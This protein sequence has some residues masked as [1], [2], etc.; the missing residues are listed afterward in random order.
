[1]LIW[2]PRLQLQ[3]KQISSLTDPTFSHLRPSERADFPYALL[4]THFQR[5][6]VSTSRSLL[7]DCLDTRRSPPRIALDSA[8]LYGQSAIA[9]S[10]CY[11]SFSVLALTYV[12]YRYGSARREP[13]ARHVRAARAEQ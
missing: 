1:M 2:R 11:F 3:I 10:S 12:V 9:V 13:F 8:V 5:A 6:M 7:S 4:A